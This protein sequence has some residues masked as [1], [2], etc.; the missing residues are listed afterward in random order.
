ME[1]LESFRK[2]RLVLRDK[3]K[4]RMISHQAIRDDKNPGLRGVMNKL[5]K[6]EMSVLVVEEDISSMVTALGNVV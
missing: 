1:G 3:E 5:L 4:V 2:P 6:E